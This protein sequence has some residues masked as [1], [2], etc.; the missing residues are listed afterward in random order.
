M[1]VL[2]CISCPPSL[3]SRRASRTRCMFL[4]YVRFVRVESCRARGIYALTA[5]VGR[6]VLSRSL[7]ALCG[8]VLSR[9]LS[10]SCA[11][12]SRY[13]LSLSS[14]SSPA[15]V[16]FPVPSFCPFFVPSPFRYPLPRSF[17]LSSLRSFRPWL[18]PSSCLFLRRSFPRIFST[19]HVLLYRTLQH[20]VVT[21]CPARVV[22]SSSK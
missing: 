8:V 7:W 15:P 16:A 11:S 3:A 14:S 4:S 1:C 17:P 12:S 18:L 5:C 6:L 9:A 2:F 20:P 22:S 21:S 10:Y 13:V 19:C